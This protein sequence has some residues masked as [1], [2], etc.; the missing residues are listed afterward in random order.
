MSLDPLLVPIIAFRVGMAGEV[1]IGLTEP[2][3]YTFFIVFPGFVLFIHFFFTVM[4]Q[5]IYCTS[6]SVVLIDII[7][8]LFFI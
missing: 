5:S 3:V 6:S 2:S 7:S 1:Y 8:Y 4:K